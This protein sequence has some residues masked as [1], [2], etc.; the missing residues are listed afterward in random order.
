MWSKRN[1][2]VSINFNL[3]SRPTAKIYKRQKYNNS[4]TII[5][6]IS[7]QKPSHANPPAHT[8]DEYRHNNI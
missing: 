3:R 7:V 6:I 5:F 4:N 8:A 1:F 2:P